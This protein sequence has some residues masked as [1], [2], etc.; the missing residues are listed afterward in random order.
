MPTID[1]FTRSKEWIPDTVLEVGKVIR[2]WGKDRYIPVRRIID[3][4]WSEHKLVK[5]LLKEVLV[6]LGV[7]PSLWPAEVGGLDISN[8][9]TFFVVLAEELG[10]MDS[11][12]ATEAVIAAAWPMLPILLRPH[13]NM[14]L[15]REFGPRFCGDEL[16]TCTLCMTEPQGGADIE[17]IGLLHG[18][19]IQTIAKLDGDDWVINGHKLWPSNANGDLHGVVCSTNP[20]STDEKDFALIYVP[21]ET[22]GVTVG[23]PYQKAGMAADYNADIWYEDARVPKKYRAMGPGEDAKYFREVLTYGNIGTAAIALGVMKNTYEIVKDWAS[24]RIISGKQLKEHSVN[25]AVLAEI[26]V[27]IEASSTWVYMMARQVDAPEIY[28]VPAWAEEMLYKTRA[29]SLFATDAAVHVTSRAMELM[30]SYGYTRAYDLEKHWRDV[31]MTTLWMGSRQ[32]DL[33][34]VARYW[35]DIETL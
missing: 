32:L 13:R 24:Q 14:D 35:F 9:A 10:R 19:T 17:N 20:G 28:G 30:G 12:F 21:K 4:D 8:T 2:Q 22:R 18:K 6:D 1:N 31:K 16:Y 29:L 7:A 3:E 5:P 15:C 11:G 34:E 26:I 23:K 27:A 25:A 33:M